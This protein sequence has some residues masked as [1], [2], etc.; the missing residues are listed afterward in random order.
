MSESSSIGDPLPHES[1]G[2]HYF[3][4]SKRGQAWASAAR[5]AAQ[6]LR[7]TQDLRLIT[8]GSDFDQTRARPLQA[9]IDCGCSAEKSDIS[10]LV[11]TTGSDELLRRPTV[12]DPGTRTHGASRP[13]QR[14]QCPG[15]TA[16]GSRLSRQTP[17]KD[18]R[19]HAGIAPPDVAAKRRGPWRTLHRSCAGRRT[20][21]YPCRAAC[22][23]RSSAWARLRLAPV[24]KATRSS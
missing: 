18:L 9:R 13:R 21:F 12:N 16:A 8:T 3:A 20:A 23:D 19:W 15:A 10:A 24:W 5:T 11:M 2:V 14:K 1:V 6:P 17:G 4:L 22:A 7:R